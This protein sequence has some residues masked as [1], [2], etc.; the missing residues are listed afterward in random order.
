MN[1][2]KTVKDRSSASPTVITLNIFNPDVLG[3][4]LP[5][6]EPEFTLLAPGSFA[7]SFA[8]TRLGD[9]WLSVGDTTPPI[10]TRMLCPQDFCLLGF[11]LDAKGEGRINGQPARPGMCI[12]A[13]P[14]ARIYYRT[15]LST[16]WAA[17]YIPRD[18]STCIHRHP[19]TMKPRASL[20]GLELFR[21]GGP[22]GRRLFLHIGKLWTRTLAGIATMNGTTEIT[23]L[24]N[25]FLAAW[26]AT[27]FDDSNAM[28]L[29]RS[30]RFELLR[31]ADD[32]L[33]ANLKRSVSMRDL[34]EATGASEG[35]LRYA[36]VDMLGL[37]PKSYFDILR[38][39]G[40]HRELM[41]ATPDET[42]EESLRLAWGYKESDRFSR[43][44]EALFGEPPAETLHRR[45]SLC[46]TQLPEL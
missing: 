46:P 3:R 41:E 1:A 2:M 5:F 12:F 32:Y 15:A 30:K 39:N 42:T 13:P 34:M 14:G 28:S 21:P 19:D 31:N 6:G 37:T 44:Y 24:E 35:A 11:L 9:G 7:A 4:A 16:K 25:D 33:R 38:L 26:S 8:Q 22:E 43:A 27:R 23:Q 17:L 36:F 20:D 10:I 45:R 18:K 40:I 29:A